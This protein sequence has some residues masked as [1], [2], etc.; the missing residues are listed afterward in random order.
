[1]WVS[2]YWGQ[3]SLTIVVVLGCH[4]WLCNFHGVWL[5]VGK[6]IND[7]FR[8]SSPL[9]S[10]G[11]HFVSSS[12]NLWIPVRSQ[13]AF[14]VF[15]VAV[16]ATSFAVLRWPEAVCLHVPLFNFRPPHRWSLTNIIDSDNDIRT[17][18]GG[19]YWWC[20]LSTTRVLNL[21]GRIFVQDQLNKRL[22]NCITGDTTRIIINWAGRGLG[23]STQSRIML[24]SHLVRG[25]Q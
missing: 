14:S 16:V 11:R 21:I 25:A 2:G 3:G 4:L 22:Q 19:F 6:H 13:L 17:T 12:N 10:T 1:M 20:G 5:G 15:L 18:N 23:K 24:K 9:L 8:T 7:R